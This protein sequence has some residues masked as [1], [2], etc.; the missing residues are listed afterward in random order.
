MVRK[1]QVYLLVGIALLVI[2]SVSGYMVGFRAG[3]SLTDKDKKELRNEEEL[4]FTWLNF[5]IVDTVNQWLRA[6]IEEDNQLYDSYLVFDTELKRVYFERGRGA[7]VRKPVELPAHYDWKLYHI[8]PNGT[9][10]LTGVIRLKNRT[11]RQNHYNIYKEA[12]VFQTRISGDFGVSFI[13]EASRALGSQTGILR[14]DGYPF[15][16][17]FYEE[18][19]RTVNKSALV[20]EEEYFS[21]KI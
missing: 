15:N 18:T 17:A 19:E 21:N 9:K 1:T 4:L 3:R 6:S 5:N 8:T 12:F 10:E 11:D 7:F 2:C 16:R 20:S 14:L 13:I